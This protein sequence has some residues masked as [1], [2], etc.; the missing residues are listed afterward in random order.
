VE[1]YPDVS[2][3][4]NAEVG[5]WQVWPLPYRDAKALSE[6]IGGSE[7]VTYS[8]GADLHLAYNGY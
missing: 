4:W 5:H 8:P 6:H 2:A 1:E 7:E 3:L